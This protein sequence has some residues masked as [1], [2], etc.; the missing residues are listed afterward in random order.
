MFTACEMSRVAISHVADKEAA[1]LADWEAFKC[2]C[3]R[4]RLIQ[5]ILEDLDSALQ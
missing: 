5:E 1:W 3:Y 2:P 4:E